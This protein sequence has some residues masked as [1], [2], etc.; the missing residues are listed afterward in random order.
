VLGF[1]QKPISWE[2]D[3]NTKELE[4]VVDVLT[5][6]SPEQIGGD[7]VATF[8]QMIWAVVLDYE[9]R[10]LKKKRTPSLNAATN[11]PSYELLFLLWEMS[12]RSGKPVGARPNDLAKIIET[13]LK[14]KVMQ[15]R[16]ENLL[17]ELLIVFESEMQAT[18][19]QQQLLVCNGIS[20]HRTAIKK[21]IMEAA[22]ALKIVGLIDT[23]EGHRGKQQSVTKEIILTKKGLAF[24]DLLLRYSI[25]T[26]ADRY[27]VG[28]V[29]LPK[30]LT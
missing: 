12:F 18:W 15:P 30:T 17:R 24:M 20:R 23:K 28:S 2:T 8:G 26:S 29:Q 6:I 16:V 21:S 7:L 25:S 1:L 19:I 11:G 14:E 22:K 13:Y 4:D 3:M 27:P 5:Q 9:S 10:N